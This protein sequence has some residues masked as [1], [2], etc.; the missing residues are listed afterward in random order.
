MTT[1]RQSAEDQDPA[2]I[3]WSV[4]EWVLIL[5]SFAVFATVR[6]PIPGVNEPHYLT[7]ARHFWDPAWCG[8]DPFLQSADAHYVFY[9]TFGILTRFLTLE[10]TAL[11]GRLIGWGLLASGWSVLARQLVPGRWAGLWSAWMFLLLAAIGNWSGEW[12]VGGIEAKVLS[13]GCAW[14]SLA[15]VLA[16]QP[17]RAAAWAGAAV[18]FH[19]V[20]GIWNTAALVFSF[21]RLGTPARLL[22]NTHEGRAGV[23]I[24]PTNPNWR[25]AGVSCLAWLLCAAPGLIPAVGML[26]GANKDQSYAADYIQVYYRLSHHLDPWTFSR[27]GYWGYAALLGLSLVLSLGIGRTPRWKV[28]ARYLLAAVLIASGGVAIRA[29]PE[30]A[31]WLRDGNYWP[32]ARDWLTGWVRYKSHLPGLLKFYP[33]RLADVAIP[34]AASLL[35]TLCVT[36]SVGVFGTETTLGTGQAGGT[37]RRM[38]AV[39]AL[40][41]GGCFAMSL[42]L[43]ALD[44]NPSRLAAQQL[45]DWRD[46]CQWVDR[47]TPRE[48]LCFATNEGWALKWYAARAEY[49]SRKDCPQDAP[50]I[51]AWNERFKRISAWSERRLQHGFSRAAIRELRQQTGIDYII[52]HKFGPFE[53]VPVY[54]NGMYQVYRLADAE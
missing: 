2:S 31:L 23:P 39:I 24:P 30:V 21:C 49:L 38:Q 8:R 51:I 35:I 4:A 54:H 14:W 18:S 6:S 42:W 22:S 29:V 9:A 5:L 3:T 33:F 32:V 37:Q 47:E 46:A 45:A 19:P 52:A 43:P 12:V 27:N 20:V 11:A 15:V 17:V 50:G 34:W 36:R 1:P 7:K 13:Y 28:A 53:I 44:R 41:F 40:L 25:S 26:R 10:Q 16:G 48:A